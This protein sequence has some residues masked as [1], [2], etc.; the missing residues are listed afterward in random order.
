MGNMPIY[1]PLFVIFEMF[2]PV[3]PWLVAVVV[4]DALLLAVAALRGA[5]RGRRAT[6]V[7]IV[8]GIV[9]AVIAALRLP[10]FTHA[11]LGDLVTAMDFVML[12]LAALGTGVAV[13]ILAFPLV[14]VLSG[15]RRG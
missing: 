8:I 15:T 13:G 11:G 12:A 10:A 2:R 14:L 7:S 9:V 6:G 5:P 4:I 1:A 3:L